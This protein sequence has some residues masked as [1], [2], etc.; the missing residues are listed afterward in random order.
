MKTRIFLTA[1]GVLMPVA[2]AAHPGHGAEGGTFLHGL[3]HPLTG[4]D[5]LLAMLAVGLWAA[6]AGGRA[7]WRLPVGFVAALLAGFGL[8][9]AGLPLPAVEPVILASVIVIGAVVALAVRPPLGVALAMVALFGLAHGHAHG[10]EG[11]AAGLAAYAAGF[12]LATAGLHA[13]GY[14]LGRGL[15]RAGRPV[16]ARA[17]GGATALAGVGLM[18]V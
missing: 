10:T 3:L 5:H 11:P 6:L 2:A 12:T 7:A 1:A 17:L 16:L 14:T 15:G 4:P 18:F 13:A 9:S 8:G